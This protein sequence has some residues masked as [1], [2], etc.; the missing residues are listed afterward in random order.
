M[1]RKIHILIIAHSHEE[2]M[3]PVRYIQRRG[4]DC[5]YATASRPEELIE[6]LAAS[7][8][9]L[10]LYDYSMKEPSATVAL[11]TVKQRRPDLPFIILA[12]S[13]TEHDAVQLMRQGA[14]DYLHKR[15]LGRLIPII[16]REHHHA[17]I[18]KENTQRITTLQMIQKR[19][20]AL[21]ENISL[22]IFL[23]DEDFR[24]V[25]TNPVF[26]ELAGKSRD[27]CLGRH[28][29]EVMEQRTTVCPDCPC[30][31]TMVTGK[32][33][34]AE[35]IW[36]DSQADPLYV[37]AIAFP[38]AD[39]PG[40]DTGF[41]VALENN[42]DRKRLEQQLQRAARLE[43]VGRLAGGLAHD[44]NN[45][46]MAVMGYS[47]L[48]MKS[49]GADDP[50]KEKL[51]LIHKAATEAGKL[52]HRLLAFGRKKERSTEPLDLNNVVTEFRSLLQRLVG[53]H[54]TIKVISA[55]NLS[56]T[57]ADRMQIEQILMNLVVNARDAMP[58]KGVIAITT[59][60]GDCDLPACSDSGEIRL[61][62]YVMLAV[63]DSGAGIDAETKSRIFD[64]FFS[65]K[66]QDKGTGLGLS[67]VQSIVRE[68]NGFIKVVSDPG[69]GARFE[70]YL[71]AQEESAEDTIRSEAAQEWPNGN[72]TV[73]IVEEDESLR[74]LMG[75]LLAFLGYTVIP[76]ENPLQA[77]N[78]VQSGEY[79]LHLLVAE[80]T[81]AQMQGDAL[82]KLL[83]QTYPALKALFL[84]NDHRAEAGEVVSVGETARYVEKPFDLRDFA[85]IVRKILDHS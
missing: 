75:E 63:A 61:C 70:I 40:A 25:A 80:M 19:Y 5:D 23:V 62:P 27:T 45:L 67:T 58:G 57:I 64:S 22:G 68:H 65:T 69:A 29:Y 82:F 13:I 50:A 20:R 32:I 43:A 41:V 39:E 12:D 60:G 18:R 1:S 8:W 35:K 85:L 7:H 48:L 77:L 16:E 47:G 59:A 84:T 42:T 56:L 33:S 14:D 55:K 38:I 54:Y 30:L 6:K 81:M 52:T 74:N 79:G 36:R 24:I 51:S 83:T 53:D 72:E 26:L 78:T 37:K 71:P 31:Q 11:H 17:S 15:S 76:V 2:A 28:C 9:D 21:V 49:V 10:A 3:N 46:I 66:S 34:E 73:L 4:Y 44:F